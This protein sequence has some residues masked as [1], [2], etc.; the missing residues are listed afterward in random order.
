MNMRTNLHKRIH[1]R[2]NKLFSKITRLSKFN[3]IILLVIIS[4]MFGSLTAYAIFQNQRGV[5]YDQSVSDNSSDSG[6]YEIPEPSSNG[7]SKDTTHPEAKTDEPS[8][9]AIAPNGSTQQLEDRNSGNLIQHTD[10]W[11][12]TYYTGFRTSDEIELSKTLQ[13]T[14]EYCVSVK[15]QSYCLE[16]DS[17]A[18]DS[19]TK[20]KQQAQESYNN[21]KNGTYMIRDRNLA[22]SSPPGVYRDQLATGYNQGIDYAYSQYKSIYDP[23]YNQY[24]QTVS[25]LN[26]TPNNCGLSRPTYTTPNYLS[27]YIH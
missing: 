24:T 6:Y 5:H 8:D 25:A 20:A 1:N 21:I 19:Y 11:G 3:I 9:L 26:A 12:C 2:I 16:K 27:D 22:L 14:Y 7:D 18:L 13:K 10:K 23:V 15:K 17:I 4:L